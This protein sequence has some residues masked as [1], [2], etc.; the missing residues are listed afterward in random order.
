MSDSYL[1]AVPA[2][3]GKV[4]CGFQLMTCTFTASKRVTLR[5]QGAITLPLLGIT[6]ANPA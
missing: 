2:V 4:E 6:A 1:S 5:G 3:A